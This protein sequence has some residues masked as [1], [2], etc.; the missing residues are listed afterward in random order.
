MRKSGGTTRTTDREKIKE[1][2][3]RTDRGRQT[4]SSSFFHSVSSVS[5]PLSLCLFLLFLWECVMKSPSLSLCL[6][7]SPSFVLRSLLLSVSLSLIFVSPSFVLRSLL[8]LCLFL[9]LSVSPSFVLRSLLCLCLFLWS[10][11]L[12][13]LSLYENVRWSFSVGFGKMT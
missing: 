3:G 2:I 8:C 1:E 12:S 4:R 6:S 7:V 11:C 5:L 9:C 10:L 13:S